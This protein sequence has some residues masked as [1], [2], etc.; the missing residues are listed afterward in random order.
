MI[1][2]RLNQLINN[3]LNISKTIGKEISKSTNAESRRWLMKTIIFPFSFP[4]HKQ[5][6]RQ[7][8]KW[9]VRLFTVIDVNE[10][11]PESI[12]DEH[13]H[14]NYF[15]TDSWSIILLHIYILTLHKIAS[16]LFFIF[17]RSRS[18]KIKCNI[19]PSRKGIIVLFSW[20]VDRGKCVCVFFSL[21]IILFLFLLVPES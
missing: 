14:I 11:L 10:I 4:L 1:S 7:Q 5:T 6:P 12:I 15:K 8:S 3:L 13:P 17:I 20:I 16:I 21:S 18:I 19:I 2:T 9:N